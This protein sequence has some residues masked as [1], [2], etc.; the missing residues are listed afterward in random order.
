MKKSNLILMAFASAALLGACNNGST[1]PADTSD[2]DV[3]TAIASKSALIVSS[4]TSKGLNI[5]ASESNTL[6]KPA[7]LYVA[8][9]FSY[10]DAYVSGEKTTVTA[11]VAW[12]V[13]SMDNVTKTAFDATHEKYTFAYA[14][15]TT[16]ITYVFTGTVT[17]QTATATATFNVS[18]AAAA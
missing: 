1:T 3:A 5:G 2:K 4:G 13:S 9:S 8:T 7:Y 16:A 11:S 12:N 17:Y 14:S 10:P 18:I 6:K 15:I